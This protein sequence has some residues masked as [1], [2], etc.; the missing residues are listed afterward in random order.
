MSR[1]LRPIDPID[2][3]TA[4]ELIDYGR[5]SISRTLADEQ[6]EGA[7]ALHNILARR[8]VAY[9]A[10]EVGMGKTYVALGVVAL[11]RVVDPGL[12]VLFISPRENIQ[13]KWVKE[14]RNFT[15]NNWRH[16][17]QRVRSIQ[18]TPV[19]PPVMCANLEEWGRE[20]VR[21]PCRD[22]FVRMSSFS[23]PLT[24][25]IDSWRAKRK[26]L[27]DLIPYLTDSSLSLVNKD[28]FK[29]NYARAF[30]LLLPTFDLVIVDEAHHLKHGRDSATSRNRILSDILGLDDAIDTDA[31]PGYG[32]R[33]GRVLFLSAT[34]LETD[35]A[36]V[37][38][39]IELFGH[40]RPFQPLGDTAIDD[41]RKRDLLGEV[42]VRRITSLNVAGVPMTKNMYRREWRG[43]GCVTFDDHLD[44]PDEKQRLIVAL[45]QKKVSEAINDEKFNASFQIG[46][47]SSFESFFETAKVAG[48]NGD[49]AT[50]DGEQVEERSEREGI[51]T[52]SVNKIARTYRRRFGESLPHPKMDGLVASL[53]G[54]FIDGEKSLVFVRRI[55]SVSELQ[56]KLS[57]EYD[58]IIRARIRGELPDIMRDEFDRVW[59]NYQSE[60]RS[61][62]ST[63]LI[64]TSSDDIS[65]EESIH[66]FIPDEGGLDTFYSWFFRG[67][68]PSGLLSGAAFRKNRL[69]S[70]GSSYS[71]FFEENYLTLIVGE[72]PGEGVL[73]LMADAVSMDR[74]D[75][76]ATLRS[77][78]FSAYESESRQQRFPRFRVFHAYQRAGLTLL[79]DRPGRYHE[80][81]AVILQGRY[82]SGRPRS[83]S[84]VPASFPEP[85][86]FVGMKTFF[87]ELRHRPSLCAELMPCN[88]VGVGMESFREYEQRRELCAS[89]ARLG[90]S[91][92]T[93]WTLLVSRL[94]SLGMRVQERGAEDRVEGLIGDFLD[95]LE[96]ERI[97]LSSKPSLT[98]YHEL[99][100]TARHF[101]LII[102]TNFPD[103][104]HVPL[105]ELSKLYASQLSGQT[106]VGGM[107]GGV[108]SKLVRQFRMP[109]YP[110]VLITTDVLQEGEDLHT[111]CSRVIHYG[112]S[113]TPSAMEQRTGRVDRVN[114]QTHRRLEGRSEPAA[115]HDLLQVHFPYLRDSV[116]LIQVRRVFE[117]MNRFL[118]KTHLLGTTE[119]Y[120]RTIDTREEFVR[121]MRIPPQ[122]RLPLQSAFSVRPE[123]LVG[124]RIDVESIHRRVDEAVRF[125]GGLPKLLSERCVIEWESHSDAAALY[126]TAWIELNDLIVPS[127]A[128]RM[129][130]HAGRKQPFALYLHSSSTDGL[131][132]LRAISPIG[133]V[134]TSTEK[135]IELVD[136][137]RDIDGAKVCLVVDEM[138]VEERERTYTV[139]VEGDILFDP[140]STQIDEVVDLL[141]RVTV[142]ADWIEESLM[143]RDEPFS[144]F[145]PDIVKEGRDADD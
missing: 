19:V 76:R 16:S 39:Q 144:T 27:V 28:E 21:D 130:E 31:W 11:L 37:F 43:G 33:C 14:L 96:E 59:E 121:A 113:W 107:W 98:A 6:L 42:M 125:L 102:D 29:R 34:P 9:L 80:P 25:N 112:I 71:T 67:A 85:D 40:G 68:G 105:A 117:R 65:D 26:H 24:D 50:F 88:W 1:T 114:S 38:K 134:I 72:G 145:R 3:S 137:A 138:S 118:D 124:K 123:D 110:I 99:S 126:G 128:D 18:R 10:D 35:Y 46:M 131:L 74:D 23:L 91:L 122:V 45:L 2:L 127:G 66:P 61:E 53:A 51:D 84:S 64:D 17:D 41:E 48:A 139:S 141:R 140:A 136:H 104:R 83:A 92:I 75:L 15:L 8:G 73:D 135:L 82:E 143:R 5:G 95:R 69:Q 87:T 56:E 63:S 49:A 30:N 120:S 54:S 93:L 70:E 100:E 81:A 133:K 94:G 79:A 60:R 4:H 115:D 101:D 97:A 142:P 77:L 89:V 20:L 12:R 116:E 132:L 103:A 44:L 62:S 36:E 58:R 13:K 119:S 129:A 108:N 57:V 7:V 106:P 52:H 86:E 47:L 111:F 55:R 78:A 109:G 22:F 90:H 32:R